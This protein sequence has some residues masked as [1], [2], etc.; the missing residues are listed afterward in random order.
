VK[1]A[2]KAVGIEN[3]DHAFDT[4][5]NIAATTKK[6]L[7]LRGEAPLLHRVLNK[8]TTDYEQNVEPL[9][10]AASDRA[11]RRIAATYAVFDMMPTTLLGVRAKIDFSF[12]ED[13]TTDLLVNSSDGEVSRR[14]IET[15][16]EA[17]RVM[18]VRS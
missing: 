16:Y 7:W 6:A 14:F 9:D 5:E 4:H 3:A 15:L 11:D 18:A 8:Q 2:F 1:E 17:A 13:C 10:E 12:D